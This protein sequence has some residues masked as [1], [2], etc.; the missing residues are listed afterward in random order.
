MPALALKQPAL[1]GKGHV[2]SFAR[3]PAKFYWRELVPGT[4]NYVIR[5]I[6]GAST[7]EEAQELCIEVYTQLRQE[8]TPER[9]Q[10]GHHNNKTQRTRNIGKYKSRPIT[11]CVGEFIQQEKA[12]VD[13]GLLRQRNFINK[14]Q[15]LNRSL[16]LIFMICLDIEI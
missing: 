15:T 6:P 5:I 9:D 10:A 13:A 4:R 14:Q 2:V 11:A 7:I 8:Q 3:E 1:N 12:R 16:S